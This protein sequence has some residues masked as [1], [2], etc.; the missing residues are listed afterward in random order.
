MDESPAQEPTATQVWPAPANEYQI[1]FSMFHPFW[2]FWP[3][4]NVQCPFCILLNAH[5]CCHLALVARFQELGTPELVGQ[6]QKVVFL[7][8]LLL[9]FLLLLLLLFSCFAV[10]PCYCCCCHFD[11]TCGRRHCG[12]GKS[13]QDNHWTTDWDVRASPDDGDHDAFVSLFELMHSSSNYAF[14]NLAHCSI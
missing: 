2:A 14:L 7:L 12:L 10:F 4:Y 5:W 13:G 9:L 11:E 8:S 6:L 1:H 3:M